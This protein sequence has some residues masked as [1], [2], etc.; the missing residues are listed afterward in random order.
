MKKKILSIV[1]AFAMVITMMPSAAFAE[2]QDADS[3]VTHF[4]VSSAEELEE[5]LNQSVEADILITDDFTID[6]TF[7]VSAPTTIRT[8]EKHT[9]TR[10]K[11]FISDFF[12]V[13]E[14]N[15]GKSS[16]VNGKKVTLNLGDPD[17]SEENMLVID[18]NRDNMLKALKVSGTALFLA[19]SPTVNIY[20]NVSII[21]CEKKTNNI[22]KNEKY[23]CSYP[24]RI[25]GAAAIVIDGTLNIYGGNFLNN[26]S[27]DEDE[28]LT[29]SD[30]NYRIS[31]QGGAIYN[32]GNVKVYGGTFANNHAARGGVFYNYKKL[33]IYAGTFENNTA[34]KYAGVTYMPDSQYSNLI[35]GGDEEEASKCASGQCQVIFRGN[36]ALS[37]GGALFGQ[38]KSGIVIYENANALFEG[39]STERYNGGAI[40]TSGAL[41]IKG[42]TTFKDNDSNSKGGAIYLSKSKEE[43]VTRTSSISNTVFTGNVAAR[44]GAVGLT[45]KAVTFE[46]GGI[47]TFTGCTFEGNQAVEKT[48]YGNEVPDTSINGGAIYVSRKSTLG[49]KDCEFTE[50]VATLKEGGAIYITDRSKVSVSGSVFVAN[51]VLDA[52]EGCGGAITVHGSRLVMDDVNFEENFAQRHGGALYC[53]YKNLEDGDF[54]SSKV[55]VRNSSFIGNES[56]YHGGGIYVTSKE[57]TELEEATYVGLFGCT[58]DSNQAENNGGA[59]Y[60]TKSR[61]YMENNEFTNNHVFAKASEEGKRYGGGA[62]YSTASS[63]NINEATMS[64]NS[65]EFNGGAIEVHTGSQ[66]VTNKVV[67]KE[68]ESLNHGGAV[69]V[70]KSD[71]KDFDGEYTNNT[72]GTYGGGLAVFTDSTASLYNTVSANNI[73]K[74]KGGGLYFF[75][76]SNSY[77]ENV[78]VAENQAFGT[79][80]SSGGGGMYI[81]G[82]KTGEDGNSVIVGSYL[83]INGGS[84]VDNAANKGGAIAAFSSSNFVLNNVEVKKNS[85]DYRGGAIYTSGSD[86]D[87]FDST[88]EENESVDYGGAIG[89]P[90]NPVQAGIYGCQFTGNKTTGDGMNGGAIWLYSKSDSRKEAKTII[91]DSVFTDNETTEYG[92]AIAL[93]NGTFL[94]AY[95]LVANGNKAEKYGGVIYASSENTIAKIAGI[96]AKENQ[97]TRGSVIY[98][99]P[100]P[101]IY[102]NSEDILDG[103]TDI[104]NIKPLEDE[105]P[106]V[107]EY[108]QTGITSEYVVPNVPKEPEIV[109]DEDA[110]QIYSIEEKSSVDDLIFDL[111]EGTPANS[112]IS[113]TYNTFPKA[114]NQTNFQSRGVTTFEDING[115]TVTCDSFILQPGD[116]TDNTIYPIGLMVYQA[117]DYKRAHPEEEVNIAVSTFRLS[118]ETAICINRES[119]YFGYMRNL[120]GKNYDKNGFVRISYLLVCAAKMG[121]NVKVIGQVEGMP[122]DDMDPGFEAFFVNHMNDVCDPA[123]VSEDDKTVADYMQFHLCQ[124]TSYDNLPAADMMHT[125]VCAV[126]NYRDKDGMD[127]GKSVWFGSANIDGIHPTGLSGRD[128]LQTAIV[129]SEHDELYRVSVNYLN[130]IGQYCGQEDIKDFRDVVSRLNEKQIKALNAGKEVDPDKQIVYLGTDEDPVFELY[131]TPIGGD[132]GTWDTV[133]NPFC[134]YVTNM[135]NSDDYILF[136]YNN[137]KYVKSSYQLARIMEQMVNDSFTKN[138]NKKNRAFIMASITKD[139][140]LHEFN[141]D[142]IKQLEVGKEIGYASVNK[143]LFKI[144]H[145]KDMQLSYSLDGQ[146]EYVSIL[147]SINFHQGASFYQSNHILVVKETDGGEG[148]VFYN[149]AKYTTNGIVENDITKASLKLSKTSYT[150]DG[151]SKKPTVIAN[152]SKDDYKVV[153][154]SNTK[155]V[156]KHTIKVVGKGIGVGTKKLTYTINPK[157]TSLSSLIP[158]EKAFRVTWKKQSTKM[159]TSRITGY[160][161][162]YSTSKAFKSGNKTETVKGYTS[163]SKTIKNLK[164]KKTYYVR[165]RTYKTVSGVKYYST[166]STKKSIKTK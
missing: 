29:E 77:L 124:W 156:G 31:S 36:K 10:S 162:Q 164:A 143:K 60:V 92:G 63:V 112:K 152:I 158:K 47:A 94:E 57:N 110:D 128:R 140:V 48:A 7:Y 59:V 42:G 142:P 8:E 151:K 51:Q 89:I 33:K 15:K 96:S 30:A 32:F 149:I 153:Y 137:V 141:G 61:T 165:V 14:N 71:W 72:S 27:Q 25:G 45:A 104:A 155:R 56:K 136:T 117:M 111:A 67:A 135:R 121:I 1:L 11:Y 35:I 132:V 126:S 80:T 98:S 130:L 90:S 75:G 166:W 85:A 55:F 23:T 148:S 134:K 74:D 161:I 108:E 20:P 101:T 131:F 120:I 21:N 26:S 69:Y 73:A 50:N 97:A 118:E 91:Q 18:G 49:I 150:Y 34:S 52:A 99:G 106:A 2:S 58:F 4:S 100:N 160:Q 65:S 19:F 78:T 66:L 139:G 68:N 95:N 28:T 43:L 9:L 22:T 70:N 54:V 17:S 115:K 87:L 145:N 38:T 86:F 159:A 88:F 154:P 62:V 81:T 5:A 109:V 44:G 3:E 64:N 83:E 147:N 41:I 146:R 127:H 46:E 116:R 40:A 157:G 138:K 113:D 84:I 37:T 79:D 119:K 93:Q 163:T 107:K 129:V 102:I 82:T 24:M 103:E 144:L 123:Y 13:G 6:R 16:I 114:N 12:V 125:K 105:V 53:S 133:N 76:G 39:N 122:L